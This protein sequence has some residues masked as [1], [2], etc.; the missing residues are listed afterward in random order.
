MLDLDL[1]TDLSSLV[2]CPVSQCLSIAL[3]AVLH[4]SA[5]FFSGSVLNPLRGPEP[6]EVER[7]REEG[8]GIYRKLGLRSTFFLAKESLEDPAS[9]SQIFDQCSA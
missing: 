7:E 1:R 4:Q 8:G 6:Q 2:S 5:S 3:D 9:M